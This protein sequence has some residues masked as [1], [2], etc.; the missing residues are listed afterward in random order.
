MENPIAQFGLMAVFFGVLVAIPTLWFLVGIK[1]YGTGDY[2]Q[3]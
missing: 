2:H 3:P 1:T